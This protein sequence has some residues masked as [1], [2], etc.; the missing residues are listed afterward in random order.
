MRIVLGNDH[1][2]FMDALADVLSQQGVTVAARAHAPHDVL[3]Q[4]AEQRPDICLIADRWLKHEGIDSLRQICRNYPDTKLVI[5]S[6]GS[7]AA[8]IMTAVDIGAAAV[9]SQHQHV[10]DL[11]NVLRRVRGGARPID[12]AA[13]IPPIRNFARPV[14]SHSDRLL[15]MLTIREQEVVMLMTDGQATKEIAEA[16]AITL[17]TARTHVQSVLVKLGAHSRLEACGIVGRSGLLGLP[18]QL[19]VRPANQKTAVGG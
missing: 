7:A 8:D 9:I 4:V 6:D 1:R 10:S 14:G 5:L 19:G 13:V 15:D 17:H 3:V 12:A 11:I 2:L 16:L 18:G